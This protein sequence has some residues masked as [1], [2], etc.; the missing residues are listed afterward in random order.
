MGSSDSTNKVKNNI[1]I[2]I[3]QEKPI[4][5]AGHKHFINVSLIVNNPFLASKLMITIIGKAKQF[6]KGKKKNKQY[7]ELIFKISEDLTDFGSQKLLQNG[8]ISYDYELNL[9]K[10]IPSSFQFE[11]NK[12][13]T[14]IFYTCRVEL[15]SAIPD[16]KNCIK[17]TSLVI[18]GNNPLIQSENEYKSSGYLK[19]MLFFDKADFNLTVKRPKNWFAKNEPLILSAEIDSSENMKFYEIEGIRYSLIQIVKAENAFK[20]IREKTVYEEV[21]Y[22]KDQ[23]VISSVNNYGKPV[24]PIIIDLIKIKNLFP[25]SLHEKLNLIY[26][27]SITPC[28]K[29]NTDISSKIPLI[30]IPVVICEDLNLQST[31]IKEEKK[32]ASAYPISANPIGQIV[33][34]LPES[35]T[36]YNQESPLYPQ[37][38]PIQVEEPKNSK[39]PNIQGIPDYMKN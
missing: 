5:F 30:R 34:K 19:K 20:Y 7:N 26:E 18:S 28:F 14:G 35:K 27:V 13:I 31:N 36:V 16:M 32:I 12:H 11:G 3:K 29:N 38:D 24:F 8:I 4:L 1:E 33:P 39:L 17:K 21:I 23:R 2:Q 22:F 6:I 25:S 10:N 37:F 9:P 15:K